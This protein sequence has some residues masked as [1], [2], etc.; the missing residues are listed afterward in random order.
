MRR[1]LLWLSLIPPVLWAFFTG[2]LW[3]RYVQLSREAARL[4]LEINRSESSSTNV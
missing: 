4:R 1:G 2:L 3:W